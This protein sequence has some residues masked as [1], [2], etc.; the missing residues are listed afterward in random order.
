MTAEPTPTVIPSPLAADPT[1]TLV[2]LITE[3]RVEVRQALDQ[4]RAHETDIASLRADHGALDTRV[5]VLETRQTTDDKHEND[6]VSRKA[7]FWGAVV[8]LASVA[9]V[10]ASI[11]ISSRHGG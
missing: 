11:L 7:V 5:T 4:I 3:L 9:A 6:R 1:T 8:A 10:V 2:V